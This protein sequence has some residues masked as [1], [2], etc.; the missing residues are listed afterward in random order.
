MRI[1]LPCP[2]CHRDDSFS[3]ELDL[4]TGYSMYCICGECL[5][6]FKDFN[7]IKFEIILGRSSQRNKIPKRYI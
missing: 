3:L 4:G 6:L 1:K 2:N 5:M 7:D